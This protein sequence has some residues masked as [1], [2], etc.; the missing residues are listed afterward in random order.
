MKINEMK[1]NEKNDFYITAPCGGIRLDSDMFFNVPFYTP[2]GKYEPY[3]SC[4]LTNKTGIGTWLYPNQIH[5][6]SIAPDKG[7]EVIEVASYAYLTSAEDPSDVVHETF[8]V[9]VLQD[10]PPLEYAGVRGAWIESAYLLWS[11]QPATGQSIIL[12]YFPSPYNDGNKMIQPI[13]SYTPDRSLFQISVTH[14]GF[15]QGSGQPTFFYIVRV[16]VEY[17]D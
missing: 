5:S 3:I 10:W 4:D 11:D 7:M 2:E 9:G 16:Q 14:K 12:Q 1:I 17:S 8:S 13:L 6:V 15:F